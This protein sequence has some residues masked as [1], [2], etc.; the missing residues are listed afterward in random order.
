VWHIDW[1]HRTSSS[2]PGWENS[3]TFSDRSILIGS[4]SGLLFQILSTTIVYLGIPDLPY[5]LVC[6]C[7]GEFHFLVHDCILES[8]CG[9][10]VKD[11]WNSSPSSNQIVRRFFFPLMQMKHHCRPW[12]NVLPLF[13]GLYRDR[14]CLIVSLLWSCVPNSSMEICV[15]SPGASSAD[16]EIWLL[17]SLD[18]LPTCLGST[19]CVS[20]GRL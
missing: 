4:P 1:S 12:W 18:T 3:P 19:P 2:I 16:L 17:F 8:L 13:E 20:T 10:Q 9:T 6:L 5:F 15:W 11:L 14:I 7:H